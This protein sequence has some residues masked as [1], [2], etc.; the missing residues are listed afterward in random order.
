MKNSIQFVNIILNRNQT[1]SCMAMPAIWQ[2]NYMQIFLSFLRA[3]TNKQ[4]NI[5]LHK[6]N[7]KKEKKI[8]TVKDLFF[9]FDNMEYL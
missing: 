9:L 8:S 1:P 6:C 7:K 5:L 2:C 3:K 4:K